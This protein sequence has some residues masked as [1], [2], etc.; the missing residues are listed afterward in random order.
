MTKTYYTY[1]NTENRMYLN[2][3]VE[4]VELDKAYLFTENE[5]DQAIKDIE[6]LKNPEQ[7]KVIGVRINYETFDI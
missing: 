5:K 3:N 4:F 1:Y 2:E 6:C 7:W